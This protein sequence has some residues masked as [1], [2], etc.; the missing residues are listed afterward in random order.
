MRRLAQLA[1]S[2]KA[3]HAL[4]K[5]SQT[6][7]QLAAQTEAYEALGLSYTKHSWSR[8]AERLAT[9]GRPDQR[10]LGPRL[11]NIAPLGALLTVK[12]QQSIAEFSHDNVKGPWKGRAR[13]LRQA[14][15]R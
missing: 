13:I 1:R 15:S 8:Q 5:I 14:V 11:K 12:P 3:R 2:V 10:C 7:S 6:W 4:L 9:L